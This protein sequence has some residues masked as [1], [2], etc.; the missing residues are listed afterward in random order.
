VD[1]HTL[2][3]TEGRR[4]WSCT[5]SA[6]RNQTLVRKKKAQAASLDCEIAGSHSAALMALQPAI[7]ARFTTYCHIQGRENPP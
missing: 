1:I 3:A 6:E 7:T 5:F 2:V 4:R